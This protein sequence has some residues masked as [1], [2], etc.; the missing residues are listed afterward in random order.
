MFDADSSVSMSV[1]DDIKLRRNFFKIAVQFAKER[2]LFC[3]LLDEV[4]EKK[5]GEKINPHFIFG[6]V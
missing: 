5:W 1:L 3:L 6:K 4:D 2:K